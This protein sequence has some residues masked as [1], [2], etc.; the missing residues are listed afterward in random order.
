M[1]I[2]TRYITS[3][4]SMKTSQGKNMKDI[5]RKVEKRMILA[6]FAALGEGGKMGRSRPGR[7]LLQLTN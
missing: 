3:L 4:G 7:E 2:K 1:G 5:N 6:G